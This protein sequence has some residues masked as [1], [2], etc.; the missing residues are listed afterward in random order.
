MSRK[1]EKGWPGGLGVL[2]FFVEILTFEV[3]GSGSLVGIACRVMDGDG[4]YDLAMVGR[5]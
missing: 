3:I 1:R 4:G 5:R 2:D